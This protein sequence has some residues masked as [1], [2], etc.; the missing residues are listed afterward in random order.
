MRVR[1]E[2]DIGFRS[3]GTRK[4]SEIGRR[5]SWEQLTSMPISR[6]QS[7]ML[8]RTEEDSD[9]RQIMGHARARMEMECKASF[10]FFS[11]RTEREGTNGNPF[12]VVLVVA[13]ASR[14]G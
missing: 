12:R 7:R 13:P 3:R 11:A 14:K 8:K 9:E 5:Y 2:L 6:T 10:F 1:K 4:G